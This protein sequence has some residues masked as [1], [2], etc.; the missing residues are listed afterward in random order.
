MEDNLNDSESPEISE[1][2][3]E[4]FIPIDTSNLDG[5]KLNKKK[6]QEGLDDSSYYAGV[7]S[8]LMNSGISAQDCMTWV[9]N[10]QTLKA[11]KELQAL[12]NENNIAV[13]K[14]QVI[15]ADGMGL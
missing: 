7:I 9:L 8:T 3:G 10:D 4:Y 13:A 2:E 1:V 6:F 11:N 15:K 14:I 5:V 12:V